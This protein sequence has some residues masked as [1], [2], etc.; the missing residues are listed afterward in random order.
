MFNFNQLNLPSLSR[1]LLFAFVFFI[2]LPALAQEDWYPPVAVGKLRPVDI[3]LEEVPFDPNANAVIIYDLSNIKV[4][5]EIK[6]TRHL[7]IKILT[8][9][10]LSWGN[11]P[12]PVRVKNVRIKG[13]V[14]PP[15][16]QG[17]KLKK[18]HLK[19]TEIKNNRYQHTLVVPNLTV[20]SIIDVEYTYYAPSI[21]YAR[22]YALQWDIPVLYSQ[23][24]LWNESMY[25][26]GGIQA[27]DN[28][29][30]T[31]GWDTTYNY[32]LWLKGSNLPAYKPEPYDADPEYHRGTV[33]MDPW[34]TMG[35]F[36]PNEDSDIVNGLSIYD[37][38]SAYQQFV[39]D[40][41]F[42][43]YQFQQLFDELS[44]EEERVKDIHQYM[45]DSFRWDEDKLPLL[46]QEPEKLWESKTGNAAEINMF[47]A[48]LLK[49]AGLTVYP[50][51]TSTR[52]HGQAPIEEK[53]RLFAHDYALVLWKKEDGTYQSLD[54]T[55]RALPF[56]LLPLYCQAR[57]G[58]AF[59]PD[60]DEQFRIQGK[61]KNQAVYAGAFTLD[62][63]GRVLGTLKRTYYDYLAWAFKELEEVG[64]LEVNPEYFNENQ[65]PWSVTSFHVEDHFDSAQQWIET[66]SIRSDDI[67]AAQ[68]HLIYLPM[69]LGFGNQER[70]LVPDSD[71]KSP[72][73][74]GVPTQTRFS[75]ILQLPP[76]YQLEDPLENQLVTL[77]NKGGQYRQLVDQQGDKL[78][79]SAIL[80]LA[81]PIYQPEE[82]P[83]L[84][85]FFDQVIA[86]QSELFVL[87]KLE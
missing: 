16:G 68:G 28:L 72:I 8:A 83:A 76:G 35:I 53:T 10:G 34:G 63:E 26:P 78:I 21:V 43:Q 11:L 73:D 85:E 31:F 38:G 66:W 51:I 60:G 45:V 44:S 79:I 30:E 52:G 49:L 5:R 41:F 14:Y 12:L 55:Q 18:E 82:Y 25:I 15:N 19:S 36:N 47:Y 1:S 75:F 64:E 4:T 37:V 29:P 20:G 6:V 59:T 32:N 22:N 86:L 39:V 57:V 42:R 50:V 13:F 84:V 70:G 58:R 61:A 46:E 80:Q 87:E 69:L 2:S 40:K 71:R 77:A 17:I 74:F 67:A 33:W 56:D 23:L 48:G 54:A 9:D 81:K 62:E 24:F 7:R 27:I 65:L 3:S